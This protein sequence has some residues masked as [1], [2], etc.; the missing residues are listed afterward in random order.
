MLKP[1]SHFT[2]LIVWQK[3]HVFAREMGAINNSAYRDINQMETLIASG[4]LRRL[5]E[6]GLLAQKGKSSATYYVPTNRL[7]AG[8][9]SPAQ[10]GLDSQGVPTG[11]STKPQGLTPAITAQPQGLAHMAVLTAY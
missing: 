5:R 8:A 10:R 4:H 2:N 7:L 1:A 6:L 9:V 11:L 3:A